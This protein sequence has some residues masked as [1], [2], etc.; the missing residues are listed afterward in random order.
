MHHLNDS[1]NVNDLTQEYVITTFFPGR[2]SKICVSTLLLSF[3]VTKVVITD[4]H[5]D[6]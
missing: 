5:F 3:R 1:W 2:I 6:M 4:D